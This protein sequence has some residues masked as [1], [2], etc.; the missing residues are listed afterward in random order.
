MA[1]VYCFGDSITYG[2]WDIQGGGW[3]NRLR[4]HLDDLQLKDD[5]LY[6]L[7]Y[8]LG[9]PGDR[10]DGLVERF[11]LEFKMRQAHD[12]GEESIFIFAFGANDSVFRPKMGT[13]V[14]PIDRFTANLSVVIEKA[15]KISQK[16]ILV[17]VLPCDEEIC[18]RRF[19]I[20]DKVRLN[21]NVEAY[22]KAL[23]LLA[24]D[25]KLPLVDVYAEYTKGT[26]G[27]FKKLLSED[28][29]H[30]NEQGHQVIFEE[31]KKQL[32]A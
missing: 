5:S 20:K 3:T 2:A 9:I 27:D 22:N 8:N 14:V 19:A 10:T 4:A 25:K 12:K 21:S 17:N 1:V 23:A 6:Y 30:P 32:Y 31:V 24:A 15:S 13:F 28:G 16:I 7:C 29:L 11:D 18:A 26:G